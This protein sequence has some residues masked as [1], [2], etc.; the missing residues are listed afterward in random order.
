[1]S[2]ASLFKNKKQ[3]EPEPAPVTAAAPAA[4]AE[5]APGLDAK[6]VAVI[7]AAVAA[8]LGQPVSELRFRA[9]RRDRGIQSAWAN[10]GTYEIIHTRQQYL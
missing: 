6:T 2:I 9:I 7:M 5:A 10:A 4:A 1:M 8:A 3:A